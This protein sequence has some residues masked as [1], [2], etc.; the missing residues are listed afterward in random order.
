MTQ[1]IALWVWF[2]LFGTVV[3]YKLQ[4]F[5]GALGW[6]MGGAVYQFFIKGML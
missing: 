6:I 1:D 5:V 2:Q 3:L 4:G